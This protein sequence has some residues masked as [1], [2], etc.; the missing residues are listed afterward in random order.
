MFAGY[1]MR[2]RLVAQACLSRLAVLGA[3]GVVLSS[4]QLT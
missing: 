4:T 1:F 3:E 2:G